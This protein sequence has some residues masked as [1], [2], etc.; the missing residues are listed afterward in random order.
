[1]TYFAGRRQLLPSVVLFFGLIVTALFLRANADLFTPVARELDFVFRLMLAGTVIAVLRNEIGMSTFG[2]FGPVILSFTWVFIGPFW[3]LVILTYIFILTALARVAIGNLDLDTAHRVA[4]LLVIAAIGMFILEAVGRLQ[5]IPSLQTVILFPVIL[6]TWYAERFIGSIEETG[7]PPGTRRLAATLLGIVAAYLVITY[8]PLITLVVETPILWVALVALNLALGVATDTRLS[9]YFR[10]STL[11]RTIGADNSGDILTMRVRNREFVA[12]YNPAPIMSA[13]TKAKMKH[14]LHGLSIPT[15]ETYLVAAGEDDL[16]DLRAL[17]EDEHQ[18]TL[19]IKPIGGSGGRDILIVRRHDEET[20][21][22]QTNRGQM[23]TND[24]ISY[25]RQI[26]V[27]SDVD[28]ATRTQ[29]LVEALI[30]PTGLLADRAGQGIPDLRIITLHGY[31]VMSM[32]RLPTEESKGTANIHTGAVAVAVDIVTGET[33]GGFHQTHN[34]FIDEHPDTGANLEFEIPNWNEVLTIASRASIASSLGYTG[35]DIVFDETEGPMVLEVNRRPGLGIQ[36]ANMAGLL[37]RLRYVES[38]STEGEYKSAAER[39]RI[40]QKWAH[41]DWEQ[42]TK[43]P[44]DADAT[45]S[46]EVN[47]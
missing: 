33:S 41:A 32:V 1:M 34:E 5:G 20:D 18:E 8:E 44:S 11:R 3:G 31:P 35:V 23:T 7:W 43:Q 27:G 21:E 4:S 38:H 14:T 19:V 40:A 13:F 12:K 2:V 47:A 17:L 15:P 42:V 37:K 26:C 39:V 45:P 30:T 46:T 10:F 6:T 16:D 28:Y 36:N 22:Y 25:T 29:A 24:I 9:E